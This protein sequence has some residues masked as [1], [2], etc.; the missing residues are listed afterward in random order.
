VNGIKCHLLINSYSSTSNPHAPSEP[1][2]STG[3]QQSTS[4]GRRDPPLRNATGGHPQHGRPV[5]GHRRRPPRPSSPPAPRT[6][7]PSAAAALLFL[8]PALLVH[9]ALYLP[10]SILVLLTP[11]RNSVSLPAPPRRLPPMATT[12][13][14]TGA[15]LTPRWTCRRRTTGHGPPSPRR[16]RPHRPQRGGGR[17]TEHCALSL[18]R[19]CSRSV[20]CLR[21]VISRRRHLRRGIVGAEAEVVVVS[22][23]GG[24]GGRG[25]SGVI[26]TLFVVHP[27]LR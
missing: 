2:P 15:V 16:R 22:G 26:M 14:T 25:S 9:P 18:L 7:G 13:P 24:S 20:R 5:P 3:M 23:G 8:P 1:S 17:G 10:A 4:G 27:M 6:G 11:A 19:P 12:T 21:T